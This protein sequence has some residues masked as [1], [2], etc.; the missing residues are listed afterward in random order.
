MSE[1]RAAPA[2]AWVVQTAGLEL[3]RDPGSPVVRLG[4]PEA[5][6][7]DLAVRGASLERITTD[8]AVIAS[9]HRDGARDLAV[10]T[11]DSLCASGFLV[12]KVA[13]G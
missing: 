1:Y 7:W 11:I 5:A 4:Y 10:R 2:V 13:D 9:L 8:L 12:R 6:V 3:F